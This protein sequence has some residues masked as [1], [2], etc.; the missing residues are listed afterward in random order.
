MV[1]WHEQAVSHGQP[2]ELANVKH[3]QLRRATSGRDVVGQAKAFDELPP[4]HAD[5]AFDLLL[6]MSRNLM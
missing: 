5:E 6:Y 4:H 2:A 1:R 3:A